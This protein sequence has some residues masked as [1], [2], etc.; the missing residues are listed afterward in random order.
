ME[1]VE[2]DPF[3][4][5]GQ[6]SPILPEA[7]FSFSVEDYFQEVDV[8][9]EHAG[10]TIAKPLPAGVDKAS[11]RGLLYSAAYHNGV[12]LLVPAPKRARIIQKQ[13]G[14]SV[15]MRRLQ[16]QPE[17]DAGFTRPWPRWQRVQAAHKEFLEWYSMHK[18]ISK[19]DSQKEVPRREFARESDAIIANWL[20]LHI[21]AQ[22]V[23]EA[24]GPGR[25]LHHRKVQPQLR[26]LLPPP[27][28]RDRFDGSAPSVKA[29]GIFVTWFVDAPTAVKPVLDA[30][31]NGKAREFLAE[32]LRFSMPHRDLFASAVSFVERIVAKISANSWAVALEM[33][34]SSSVRRP[35]QVHL[36]FFCCAQ[37]VEDD[38]MTKQACWMTLDPADLVFNDTKPQYLSLMK[39][40]RRGAGF[41][42][43]VGAM[44]YLLSNKR[45]GIFKQ[46]SHTPFEDVVSLS[47][48]PFSSCAVF[49]GGLLQ[50]A[51]VFISYFSEGSGLC[52][53]PFAILPIVD[54]S[55]CFCLGLAGFL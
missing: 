5:G 4:T 42:G 44:Y 34:T 50:P 14:L 13:S 45:G 32:Q 55:Y 29:Q 10:G 39:G 51:F 36:H 47:C 31:A 1:G 26:H 2:V 52:R 43:G 15:Y 38:T 7:E 11:P 35:S 20:L 6:E 49:W 37:S 12:E 8:T 17:A 41:N 54:L 28:K 23:Y 48:L 30:L 16:E 40:G 22:E 9:V 24:R 3:G 53:V 46:G 19:G 25:N 27:E 21:V 33:G 18:Q